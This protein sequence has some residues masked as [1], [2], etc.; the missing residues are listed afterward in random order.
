MGRGY[1]NVFAASRSHDQDGRHDHDNYM[2]KSFRKSSTPEPVDGFP[3]NFV[4]SI[5]D[6][7]SS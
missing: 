1:E 3:R 2:V 7:G 6:P 5:G 4:C